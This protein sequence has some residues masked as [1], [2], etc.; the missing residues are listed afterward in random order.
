MGD[1]HVGCGGNGSRIHRHDSLQDAVFAAAQSAAL[2][3]RKEVP[4]LI[5][6]SA[7]RPADV[8]LPNWDRGFPAALDV[9][10]ICTLQDLTVAGAAA[11]P[12]HALRIGEERKLA[13]HQSDC[14]ATGSPLSLWWWRRWGAGVRR[15]L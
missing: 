7:N 5:P 8:F 15:L 6:G 14:R 12:G 10:V 3:P 9:T 1:H 4:A 13:A 2:A 11:T